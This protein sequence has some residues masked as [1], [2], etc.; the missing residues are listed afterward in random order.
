MWKANSWPSPEP[1]VRTFSGVHVWK[2]LWW[3]P[4]KEVMDGFYHWQCKAIAPK[5]KAKPDFIWTLKHRHFCQEVEVYIP[6][7]QYTCHQCCCRAETFPNTTLIRQQK[8][9]MDQHTYAQ[10]LF[11]HQC[12]L[13]C[14]VKSQCSLCWKNGKY[15]GL[16]TTLQLLPKRVGMCVYVCVCLCV[17]VCVCP[18]GVVRE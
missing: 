1:N 4:L 6:G 10:P 3:D 14:F 15:K 17:S 5:I 16:N 9:K 7:V 11:I 13:W 12:E 8:Q 2:R 18:C